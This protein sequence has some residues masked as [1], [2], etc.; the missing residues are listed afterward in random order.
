MTEPKRQRDHD[1]R[2]DALGEFIE[3][4]ERELG[5]ISDEEMHALVRHDRAGA[6]MV[7]PSRSRQ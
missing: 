7:R 2:L 3:T 4:Y 5:A 6:T 1:V